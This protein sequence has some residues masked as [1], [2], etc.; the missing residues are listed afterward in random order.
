MSKTRQEQIDAINKALSGFRMG[1]F[2]ETARN[3]A[4]VLVDTLGAVSENTIGGS[5][6]ADAWVAVCGV[7]HSVSPGWSSKH[8]SGQDMAVDAIRAL[9]AERDAAVKRAE[10]AEREVMELTDRLE[11]ETEWHSV[12]RERADRE[13]RE[14]ATL[15]AQ[16]DAIHAEQTPF[17]WAAMDS[18]ECVMWIYHT[19]ENADHAERIDPSTRIV[20]LYRHPAPSLPVVGACVVKDG[21][22]IVTWTYYTDQRR[23]KEAAQRGVKEYGGTARLLHVGAEIKGEK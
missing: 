14:R 21:N 10:K 3:L 6:H 20:P 7:L 23:N 12:Q 5:Q 1:D 8:A 18:K 13:S 2:A 9:A 22:A 4:T 11:T 19:K 17:R 15:R 16:L